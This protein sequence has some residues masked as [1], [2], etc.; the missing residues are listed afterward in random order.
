MR[1]GYNPADTRRSDQAAGRDP[2]GCRLPAKDSGIMPGKSKQDA[3]MLKDIPLFAGLDEKD[4]LLLEQRANT[5]TFPKHAILI[6]EGD[7]TDSL[8]VILSGKVRVFMSNADGKEII[9]NEQGPG[10]H[11][12]ELALIDDAPRSAS[13]MAMEKTQ[14]SV[15][16]RADFREVL[17]RHPDIAFSLIRELGR[18]VRLLSD[19]VKN[20][21][22]LDVYGRVAKT[23]LGMAREIDGQLVI[24]ERPTQQD[25]ANHIGASREMVARILKDLETG[26]YI[27]ITKK[28]VLINEKLPD[29]Y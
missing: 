12:G 6:N 24:E 14:V 11:F 19:N 3:C 17:G 16:S 13:V 27:T 20:L 4:Q 7:E 5:R 25:I 10:E 1:I 9:L 28:Q 2:A 29:R 22:L 15:I 8:Y 18:R 21:A 23:L 26:G